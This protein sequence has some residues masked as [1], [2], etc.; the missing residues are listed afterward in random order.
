[1]RDPLASDPADF[2]EE[3]PQLYDELARRRRLHE[4]AQELDF[5]DD[6]A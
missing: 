2:P 5:P 1:M 4:E 6:A 3:S